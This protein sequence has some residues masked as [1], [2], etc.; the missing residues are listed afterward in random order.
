[1]WCLHMA[2]TGTGNHSGKI[3]IFAVLTAK[4]EPQIIKTLVL[5]QI[6]PGP[7]L[8]YILKGDVK[9]TNIFMRNGFPPLILTTDIKTLENCLCQQEH[10]NHT[11][12]PLALLQPPIIS[13]LTHL[14]TYSSFK[15]SLF[16]LYFPL[17]RVS[18]SGANTRY[19]LEPVLKAPRDQHSCF[20]LFSMGIHD[21]LFT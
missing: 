5:R 18:T 13:R 1:M 16:S 6:F 19:R 4:T 14:A 9:E 15:P 3:Y 12:V 21:L 11:P 20:Q 10:R 8:C 2:S 7:P 17:G